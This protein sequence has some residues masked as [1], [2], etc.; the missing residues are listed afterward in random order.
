[1]IFFWCFIE[2]SLFRKTSFTEAKKRYVYMVQSGIMNYKRVVQ[3][4]PD[5]VK[6][7]Y[8]YIH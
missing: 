5:N 8:F 2:C 4:V 7:V 1:M 6:R 3:Q